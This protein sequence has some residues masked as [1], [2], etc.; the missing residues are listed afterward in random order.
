[1]KTKPEQFKEIIK[2]RNDFPSL[3]KK[4]NGYPLA[5][6]DGPGGS[7][8]PTKV[9]EA[10]SN[11]YKNSNA[12]THGYF[13][14]SIESDEM[15]LQARRAAADFI[16]AE[17]AECISFGA[18]MTTL[19]F[20]LSKAIG[21][22]LQKGEEIVI[23]QLDH[24]AN[25]GPWLNLREQGIVVR[26][27]LLKQDGTLDYFDFKEKI[28]ERTRLVAM[29][30]S[31]NAL[32]TVNNVK[33]VRQ[34]TYEVGA[35]LMVDAV[36]YAP[37]F[38][39]DVKSLGVDFLICSAYKFYG[40]HVGI[41]YSREGLLEQLQTDRLRTQDPKAPYRIE[42]GTLNHAAIAGVKAAIEYIS[43]FG[44]GNS[45][46]SKLVDAMERINSYEHYLASTLYDELK[47]INGVKVFGQSFDDQL[48]APTVS[49]TIAGIEPSEACKKF[50]EKGICVWDGN[51]YAIRAVEVLGLFEKGGLIRAGISLYNTID[52]V[53]RLLA[54]V[55]SISKKKSK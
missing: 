24:E 34:L 2:H 15:I 53:H 4:V 3:N 8:V 38:S 54:E 44:E 41:L 55:K 47:K 16:G 49:F 27:V 18:N 6:L 46:R 1:M 42:T 29:G 35:L 50:G 45:F 20:S 28:N 30:L 37:H 11:Y 22:S 13:I 14:T 21:R 9:I 52:E 33:L 43:S 23:T 25:R 32:G 26:E 17:N 40:P 36:H 51:F 5:Y 7:Q 48:R 10:I 19:N 31:S 39:I 12:N